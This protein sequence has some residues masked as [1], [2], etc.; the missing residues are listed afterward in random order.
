MEYGSK[1]FSDFDSWMEQMNEWLFNPL[2]KLE[3]VE[4]VGMIHPKLLAQVFFIIYFSSFN[5]FQISVLQ[6]GICQ[7]FLYF[8]PNHLLRDWL[9]YFNE[10]H[11]N[12]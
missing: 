4:Y 8:I 9:Y 2:T 6:I 1:T 5:T 7:I 12:G 3:D 10:S 11:G